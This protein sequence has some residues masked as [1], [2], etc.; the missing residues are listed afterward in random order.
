VAKHHHRPTFADIVAEVESAP[1]PQERSAGY[2]GDT[3]VD[4]AGNVYGLTASDIDAARA[5]ELAA[6]GAV[7]IWDDCG[8][9]GYCGLEWLDAAEVRALVASGPPDILHKKRR[10]GSIAAYATD[11]GRPL[12]YVEDAVRWGRFG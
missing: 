10:R 12:L 3:V 4:A 6:T 2:Y 7:V 8:C 1:P 11:D 9:G 5:R